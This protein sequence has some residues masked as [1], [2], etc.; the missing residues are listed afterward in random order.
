MSPL[1]F[2]NHLTRGHVQ[3]REKRSGP[4]ADVIVGL[5]L[6]ETG[7]QGKHRP[8]V[9]QRLDLAL[10]VHAQHYG[11]L[12]RVQIQTHNIAHL[13]YEERIG[14]ELEILCAVGLQTESAPDAGHGHVRQFHGLAQRTGAPVGGVR[15]LRLQGARHHLFHLGIGDLAR[16]AGAGLI[17]Q[18]FQAGG[19]KALPPLAHRLAAGSML[20]S[21]LLIGKAAGTTQYDAGA[22]AKRC[23]VLGRRAHRCNFSRSSSVRTRGFLGRPVSMA[24]AYQDLS[25]YVSNLCYNT[26]DWRMTEVDG[27]G[28]R[29]ASNLLLTCSDARRCHCGPLSWRKGSSNL[30]CCGKVATRG[31][32]D[33]ARDASLLRADPP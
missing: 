22:K 27:M 1:A 8:S 14:R 13:L 24:E 7:P 32:R 31:Q 25:T 30:C 19:A 4:V 10:L 20:A 21:R 9:V 26:L 16:W 5:L 33:R 29:C 12:G 2:P 28:T 18:T 15:R 17:H 23:A 6:G 11:V 3:G